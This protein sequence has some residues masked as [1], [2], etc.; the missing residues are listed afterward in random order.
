MIVLGVAIAL[1]SVLAQLL[2]AGA[3]AAVPASHAELEGGATLMYYGG[4]VA[5]ILLA[6][7]MVSTWQPRRSG[8]KDSSGVAADHRAGVYTRQLM[9]METPFSLSVCSRS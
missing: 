3:F 7:A 4:D 9:S 1:H 2:Y 5:E 6:F 8:L